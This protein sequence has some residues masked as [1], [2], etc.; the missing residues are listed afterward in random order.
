M[1]D[2][3]KSILNPIKEK[4]GNIIGN[5][6]QKLP[7]ITIPDKF[8]KYMK[9]VKFAGIGV[10]CV[11]VIGIGAFVVVRIIRNINA[12]KEEE[13]V[14]APINE[15]FLNT[16][17]IDTARLY[18]DYFDEV[19]PE[20]TPTPTPP[21][22]PPPLH[23]SIN[24][25]HVVLDT[26]PVMVDDMLYVPLRG[27]FELMG[28]R[29]NWDNTSHTAMLS[30]GRNTFTFDEESIHFGYRNTVMLTLA[31]AL[32]KMG[33]EYDFDEDTNIF[34]IVYDVPIYNDN[35]ENENT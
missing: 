21:P 18:D 3:I 28:Y 5:V 31:S 13:I 4:L 14:I 25:V 1:L 11:V 29:V 15:R 10:I 32:D 6:T 8:A 23:V 33:Y 26:S 20:P 24:G 12:E 27:V 17:I 35:E 16:G 22:P 7:K 2:K 34:S 9:Y 19:E 30:D